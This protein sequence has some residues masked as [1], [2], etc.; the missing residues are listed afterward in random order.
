MVV[1]SLKV[2]KM[3]GIVR[4]KYA[5]SIFAENVMKIFKK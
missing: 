5:K 2:E 3:V 1:W 4:K